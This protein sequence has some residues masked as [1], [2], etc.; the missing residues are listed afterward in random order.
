MKNA[1]GAPGRFLTVIRRSRLVDVPKVSGIKL[2]ERVYFRL[3]GRDIHLTRR[4]AIWADCRYRS[5]KVRK[6]PRERRLEIDGCG[7]RR[8]HLQ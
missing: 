1:F 3:V 8:S 5:A 2:G 7:R 4:P 6:V